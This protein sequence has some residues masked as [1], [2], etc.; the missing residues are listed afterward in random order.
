M[1]G[2]V[3]IWQYVV[4]IL[5]YLFQVHHKTYIKVATYSERLMGWGEHEARTM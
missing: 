2:I 1:R 5:V 4:T 3:I